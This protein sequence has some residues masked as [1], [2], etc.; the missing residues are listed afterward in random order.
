M[1]E[2]GGFFT[3]SLFRQLSPSDPYHNS[4]GHRQTESSHGHEPE[5]GIKATERGHSQNRTSVSSG[6]LVENLIVVDSSVNCGGDLLLERRS[7]RALNV[8]AFGQNVA[9]TT[10]AMNPRRNRFYASRVIADRASHPNERQDE[11]SC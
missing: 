6:Q 4:N 1:C 10:I 7:P 2:C 5:Q 11:A 9:T 8:R 3:V